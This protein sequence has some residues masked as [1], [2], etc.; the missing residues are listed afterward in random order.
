MKKQSR[1]MGKWNTIV[2]YVR[3]R[4]ECSM[5]EIEVELGYSWGEQYG[6]F[7][8]FK[9]YAKDIIL[10]RRRWH[11]VTITEPVIVPATPQEILQ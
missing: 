4:G 7:G 6:L 2:A 3:K 11:L 10:T 5:G 1:N 9:D 8:A